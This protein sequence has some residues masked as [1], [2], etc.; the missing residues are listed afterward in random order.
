MVIA[1]LESIR[2]DQFF[3][4]PRPHPGVGQCPA[5]IQNEAPYSLPLCWVS[6]SPE[7]GSA[8]TEAS[9]YDQIS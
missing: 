8:K 2:Q 9:M 6:M 5:A 1:S 7:T 3:H 4:F